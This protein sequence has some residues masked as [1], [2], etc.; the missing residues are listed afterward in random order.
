MSRLSA[1]GGTA[2]GRWLMEAYNWF[3]A[4][5]GAIRHAILLTDGMNE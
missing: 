1:N 5:P 3:A 4:Y 2:I